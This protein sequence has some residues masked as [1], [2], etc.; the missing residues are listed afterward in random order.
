MKQCISRKFCFG[1]GSTAFDTC[2]MLKRDFSANALVRTQTFEWFSVVRLGENLVEDC[3]CSG[4]P[5][6]VTLMEMSRMFADL[7]I[8]PDKAPFWRLLAG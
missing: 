7:S 1:L 4:C 6:T 8:K 5:S 3:K 2:E